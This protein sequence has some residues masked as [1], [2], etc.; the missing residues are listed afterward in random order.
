MCHSHF[1]LRKTLVVKKKVLRVNPSSFVKPSLSNLLNC[2]VVRRQEEPS[3]VNWGHWLAQSRHGTLLIVNTSF[4]FFL[5]LISKATIDFLRLKWHI[6]NVSLLLGLLFH[7]LFYY[8]GVKSQWDFES[9]RPSTATWCLKWCISTCNYG[10][11]FLK[12]ILRCSN[13]RY[14][15]ILNF[16]K[17]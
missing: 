14:Y 4:H 3:E 6:V 2:D 11:L 10:T 17:I 8:K 13:E 12:H 7:F 15:L 9:I 1:D 16:W 5:M